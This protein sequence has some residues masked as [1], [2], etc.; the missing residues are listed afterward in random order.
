[1]LGTRL[2]MIVHLKIRVICVNVIVINAY[3]ILAAMYKDM[4]RYRHAITTILDNYKK[5]LQNSYKIDIHL[6]EFYSNN[7]FLTFYTLKLEKDL[8]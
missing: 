5:R 1:M 6:T 4:I 2:A 3:K 7:P 8:F